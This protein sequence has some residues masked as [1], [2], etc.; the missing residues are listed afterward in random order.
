M[1]NSWKDFLMRS[2]DIK[3]FSDILNPYSVHRETETEWFQ[4]RNQLRRIHFGERIVNL[5]RE[6]K[7]VMETFGYIPFHDMTY[8]EDISK[9]SIRDYD[10]DYM[11]CKNYQL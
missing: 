10:C 7:R 2:T 8:A 1:P 11:N 4:W 6:C 5:Q 3:R 9:P